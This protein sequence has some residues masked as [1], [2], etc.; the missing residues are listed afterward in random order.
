MNLRK[1]N[2][3]SRNAHS[4]LTPFLASISGSILFIF[5]LLLLCFDTDRDHQMVY[6]AYAVLFKHKHMDTYVILFSASL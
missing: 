3:Q 1:H 4:K 6:K 2:K 5:P